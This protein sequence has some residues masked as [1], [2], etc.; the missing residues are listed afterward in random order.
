MSYGGGGGTKPATDTD[1]AYPAPAGGSG[2]T[3]TPTSVGWTGG[4]YWTNGY[5]W[6]RWDYWEYTDYTYTTSYTITLD[7]AELDL[8]DH[9]GDLEGIFSFDVIY[10]GGTYTSTST[11]L[12]NWQVEGERIGTHVALELT[13]LGYTGS[14]TTTT[15]APVSFDLDVTGE[16][17]EGD[18]VIGTYASYGY[19]IATTSGTNTST[20][21]GSYWSWGGYGYYPTEIRL[22]CVF[23][24][25]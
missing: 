5:Y 21:Y 2:S 10:S 23:D 19:D 18:L 7:P 17:M 13:G 11:D 12:A 3:A 4:A 9:A 20:P 15:D 22:P 6:S 25:Q 8:E 16:R 14:S 24:R 1:T